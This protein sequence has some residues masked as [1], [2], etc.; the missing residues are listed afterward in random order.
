MSKKVLRI[1]LRFQTEEKE[2]VI[3]QS[4]ANLPKHHNREGEVGPFYGVHYEGDG[5]TWYNAEQ[6]LEILKESRIQSNN[7]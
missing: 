1:G 7:L 5:Y 3:L 6:L 2:G 4:C